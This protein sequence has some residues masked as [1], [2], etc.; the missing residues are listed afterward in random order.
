[1]ERWRHRTT[2]DEEGTRLDRLV[3]AALPDL[4]RSRIKRLIEEGHVTVDGSIVK[5]GHAV[6]PGETIVVVVPA[7]P[8]IDLL[9]QDIPVP[10]V[11]EDEVLLVVDKPAGLAVH[12][13]AGRPDGT[14]VNA[15]LGRGTTLSPL[16][17]PLRPGVVH[18]LDRDTS[19]LLVVAKTEEVHRA[20]A[21]DLAERKV[22]RTY[23][24]LVW[25]RPEPPVG[26]IEGAIGRSRADRRRMRVVRH[27][28]KAAR[29]R[30]RT[31]WS[32]PVGSALALRL[33]TG[34]THQIRAHCKYLGIPVFGDPDY[35][36]RGRKADPLPAAP[37]EAARAALRVLAR[38]ALHAAILGFR[39][40]VRGEDLRFR[41]PLP[42]DVADAAALLGVP[43]SAL[44]SALEDLQA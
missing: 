28:G 4:T 25:G 31:L 21:L 8:V 11:Y 24:A 35:G 33:E 44:T 5:A 14:L 26:L 32:G 38:Q 27:G 39:H 3:Q 42:Q 9:P 30:Y 29:T 12:P 40:P 36:G 16:G 19:G 13:G 43:S 1:M 7:P 18:R 20:L 15:L 22:H 23:W 41:S 34:R 2:A 17:A 10:V 37:R 6:R